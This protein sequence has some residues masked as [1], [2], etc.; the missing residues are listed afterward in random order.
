M[1][2]KNKRI[3]QT[4]SSSVNSQF[5]LLIARFSNIISTCLP[6]DHKN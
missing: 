2:P 3:P 4:V 1:F 5:K 6:S